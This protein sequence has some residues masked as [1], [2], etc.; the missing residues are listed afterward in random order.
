[1]PEVEFIRG[2]GRNSALAGCFVE[3]DG[4][5]DGGVEAFDA[6]GSVLGSWDGDAGVGEGEEFGGE[7]GAFVADHEGAGLGEVGLGDGEGWSVGGIGHGGVEVNAV[8]FEGCDLGRRGGDDGE[9]EDGAGGGSDGFLV[10]RADGAGGG[11]DGGGAEASAER[12]RVPR[13]PGSWRAAAMRMSGAV[14]GVKLEVSPVRCAPVEMTL[15]SRV[16]VGGTRRAAMPW[17]DWVS[18]ALAKISEA[19]WMSSTPTGIESGMERVR[20]G[21]WF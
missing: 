5:G 17:G 9:A 16:Q 12:M 11:E 1:M 13:L 7:A 19:S 10:P 20:G 15:S 21:R 2:S 3:E 4:G 18:T 6:G 8:G 14:V